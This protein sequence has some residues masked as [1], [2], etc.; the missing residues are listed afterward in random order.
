[1]TDRYDEAIRGLR[2]A[3]VPDQWQAITARAAGLG[4]AGSNGTTDDDGDDS[5]GADG[6]GR[7]GRGD[8]RNARRWPLALAAASS[9]ALVAGVVGALALAGR[10]NADVSTGNR[11]ATTT[12]EG[13]PTDT[14]AQPPATSSTTTTTTST[15]TTTPPTGAL[16]N[17]VVDI[18]N[19]PVSACRGVRFTATAP[20]SGLEGSMQPVAFD[21]PRVPSVVHG[22][23]TGVFP[24]DTTT[25]AVFVVAGWPGLQDDSGTYVEGPFPDVQS[26]IS[27]YDDGWLAEIAAPAS[28]ESPVTY[29]PFTLLGLGMNEADFR[30]FLGGLA[31]EG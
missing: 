2:D 10:D 16:P 14:S 20:P 31:L 1:M 17:E 28:T 8:G 22:N 26:W 15:T 25:R 30:Q 21:D 23:L 19:Y 18:D 7:Q 9:L 4:S 12:G 5:G 29:C 11:P 13:G 6:G 3:P 27:A 24:S